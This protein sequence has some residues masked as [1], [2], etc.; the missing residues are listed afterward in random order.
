MWFSLLEFGLSWRCNFFKRALLKGEHK[1]SSG[2]AGNRTSPI[3]NANL[4]YLKITI[5]PLGNGSC[6]LSMEMVLHVQIIH[7]TFTVIFKIFKC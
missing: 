6:P 5:L 1:I 3:D 7:L 2:I 4:I